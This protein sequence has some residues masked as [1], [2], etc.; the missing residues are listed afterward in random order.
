MTTLIQTIE[1][2]I[3]TAWVDVEGFV[4]Q[5]AVTIWDTLK[6]VFLGLLPAQWTI[7]TGLLVEVEKDIT[8]G[9]IADLETGLLNAAETEELAWVHELG[10]ELLQ[11][12]IAILKAQT[13]AS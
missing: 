8:T 2:D 12:V 11:A 1:T 7:L 9:D 6:V 4:E 3:Q 5:E 10:T 13:P